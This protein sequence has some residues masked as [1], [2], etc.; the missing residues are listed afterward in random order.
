M[1][2]NNNGSGRP[3]VRWVVRFLGRAVGRGLFDDPYLDF[4]IEFVVSFCL[5]LYV[6]Y[7]AFLEY[8]IC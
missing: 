7:S 1:G 3:L 5:V 2:L 6:K 4:K 8:V